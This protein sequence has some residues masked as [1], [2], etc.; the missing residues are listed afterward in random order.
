[1]ALGNE[2]IRGIAAELKDNKLNISKVEGGDFWTALKIYNKYLLLSWA[3][4]AAGC[5]YADESEIIALQN[6]THVTAPIAGA[7]KSRFAKAE[8]IDVNQINNDRVLEFKIRRRVAAGTFIEY[9]LILEATEPV[10]NLIL[11]NSEK[12]IEEA[13]RHSAPDQNSFRTI[14]PGHKYN[15]PPVFQGVN[16]DLNLNLEFEDVLNISGICRPLAKAIQASWENFNA[17]EWRKIILESFA[18]DN[19]ADLPP[20]KGEVSRSDGG[21]NAP[22]SKNLYFMILNKNYLTRFNFKFRDAKILSEQNILDAARHGVIEILLNKGR[23]KILRDIKAA[24]KK[25]VKSRERHR[26]GLIKQLKECEM[27]EIF[28][29]KGELILANIYNIKPRA[30]SIIVDDW[31][32]NKIEIEL[33]ANLSPSRNAEKYFKKYKKFNNNPDLIREKIFE[34]ESAINEINEQPSILESISGENNFNNAV[35]DLKEWLF[36]EE[37][38]FKINKSKSKNNKALPP[39]LE[40]NLE[41]NIT[42]LVG[43][44]ARGNRYVTFKLARPDDI[45]LHAHE[46]PG[47]HVIIKGASRLELEAELDNILKFAAQ[48]AAWYSKG[49]TS[50]LVLVDYT[51]RRHVRAV[52]GT[53]ALVTYVNPGT[54][55]VKPDDKPLI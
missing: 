44:S 24:I 18:Q 16:L 26:D 13:A 2:F 25:A 48:L 31:S 6:N 43:L 47:S 42:V 49:R 8:I 15:A 19:N 1:M 52:P 54:I 17:E 55:R 22:P 39:H 10:A 37:F 4:G 35:R 36:P 46:L 14:L 32:G 12:I 51:E 20:L 9:Y 41:N 34:I 33:D 23:E 29:I 40:F 7:L 11:L 27:A 3:S 30:E 21:V 53:V 45:W 50:G 28:K 38:K 5:C